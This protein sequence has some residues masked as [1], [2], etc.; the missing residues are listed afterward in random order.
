MIEKFLNQKVLIA[1]TG[2][3]SA[4]YSVKGILTKMD[5]NFVE[6]DNN[7]IIAIKYILSIKSL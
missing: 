6:V 3:A 5:D 7:Q 1:Y 2:Y 4:F